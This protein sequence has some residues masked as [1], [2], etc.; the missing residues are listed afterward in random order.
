MYFFFLKQQALE[1]TKRL[2]YS[3]IQRLFSILETFLEKK[4]KYFILVNT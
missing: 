4:H 3:I 2:S 1:I